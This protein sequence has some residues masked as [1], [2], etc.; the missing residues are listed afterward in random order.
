MTQ[1]ELSNLSCKPVIGPEM[2][3]LRMFA[4][5]SIHALR[6]L[7]LLCPWAENT[8]RVEITVPRVELTILFKHYMDQISLQRP[9]VL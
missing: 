2:N 6:P 7:M 8:Y 3:I 4:E 5:C 9:K 1:A